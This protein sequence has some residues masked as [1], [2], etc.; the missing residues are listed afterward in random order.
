MSAAKRDP[1]A[2]CHSRRGRVSRGWESQNCCCRGAA[3]RSSVIC[4]RNGRNSARRKSPIVLRANDSTLKAELDRLNF[5]N[6]GRINNP[7]PECGMFSSIL[8]AA[9][10]NGWRREISSWAVVLGDQP[11][12]QPATLRRLLEFSARN[13]QSICQ[14]A[15]AGRTGHPVILPR[16]AF[17]ELKNSGA[18]TLKDFL[19][20]TAL[21]RVQC[22][23]AEPGLSLDMDTPEHYKRLT[24]S[25]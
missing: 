8:C 13:Q 2:C 18:A 7:H 9:N 3:R 14:P 20:L 4:L 24:A 5:S 10:W 23:V 11:H 19:K 22:S 15:F 17:A 25:H 1:P 21:P 6:Q 12:L 16:R